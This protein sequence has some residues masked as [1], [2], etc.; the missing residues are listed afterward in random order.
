MKKAVYLFFLFLFVISCANQNSNQNVQTNVKD[1][2]FYHI[3]AG[4]ENPHRA[5]MPLKMA[6]KMVEDK[7][8]LIYLDIDAPKL[9][10]KSAEDITHPEFESFRT[11]IKKLTEKGVGIYV[12]PTCLKIAGFTEQDLIEGVKIAEK[13]KFF[14]F[15]TGRILTLDY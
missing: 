14:T 11:Y 13:E 9:V 10:V 1:G 8:V 12:C 15:T 2:V 6:M 4:P 5:L 3:T 7:D